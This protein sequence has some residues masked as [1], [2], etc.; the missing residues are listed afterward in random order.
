MEKDRRNFFEWLKIYSLPVAAVVLGL[1]IAGGLYW[2]LRTLDRQRI[3]KQFTEFSRQQSQ[4]LQW[5]LI[6]FVNALHTAGDLFATIEDVSKK[7]FR[8]LAY[9]VGN[10]YPGILALE[11]LPKVEANK[12][13]QFVQQM[14]KEHG[15][16][17]ITEIQ[18]DELQAAA[19]RERYYP[20]TYVEPMEADYNR[21]FLG[22][23]HFSEALRRDPLEEALYR[24]SL[25]MTTTEVFER[26]GAG[27]RKIRN[28]KNNLGVVL[29]KPVYDSLNPPEDDND[30]TD[31]ARGVISLLFKIQSAMRPVF[32]ESDLLL[33]VAVYEH[34]V[35]TNQPQSRPIYT[36]VPLK[37]LPDM[38]KL[39]NNLN[40]QEQ[41]PIAN[42]TWSLVLWP[43][44]EYIKNRE[45]WAPFLAL[46]LGFIMTGI[47]T[48]GAFWLSN[49]FLGRRKQF[50][51]V[52][53]SA[54]D[55]I[56]CIDN[57]GKVLLWNKA[58]EN[59]FGYPASEMKGKN[60]KI[61]FH[62][63]SRELFE[64]ELAKFDRREKSDLHE[65]T[66]ELT[67]TDRKENI[68]P[69]EI[70]L[71]EWKQQ[72]RIYHTVIIRDIS[73]RVERKK[74]LEKLNRKLEEK[75][76]QRTEELEQFVY[77]ASHDLREPARVIQTYAEFLHED[78]E[79]NSE[80]KVKEDLNFIRD[81]AVQMNNLIEALRKLSRVGRNEIELDTVDLNNC[82]EDA[83]QRQGSLPEKRG[84]EIVFG[85]LPEIEADKVLITDLYHNLLN[86][87]LKHGGEQLSK[88]EFTVEKKEDK[89]LLGVKDDGQG[90]DAEFHEV[91]FE[92]FKHLNTSDE[93]KGTGI[94]LSVCKRIVERHGGNI[95]VESESG[96]GT[97]ILFTIS[98]Q[99]TDKKL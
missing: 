33:N 71:S 69:V 90:I 27:E 45:S 91:I 63:E 22:F 38:Q 44:E 36:S 6:N 41:F 51:S 99:F 59:I 70:T 42:R 14:K 56:T 35:G 48:R 17:S 28:Q 72:N 76:K 30:E 3:E 93:N 53:N 87:A 68:F 67:A 49:E 79:N 4:H 18:E 97:H 89:W 57:S 8:D 34:P 9:I 73:E 31:M 46:I 77:A 95:W 58:A 43:T 12:R 74:R 11:W 2:Q 15:E 55:A 50:H 66:V 52:I 23:D 81:S 64:N 40:F 75:V 10:R 86:N 5:N 96:E 7:E 61:I 39:N 84:V 20:V 47:L 88:I 82:V 78:L 80:D 98:R 37:K 65:E 83:I 26:T 94:G 19:K 25:T 21:R 1:L 54:E 13:E 92:P 32:I 24:G 60:L 16:F 29:Y 62:G 85:D